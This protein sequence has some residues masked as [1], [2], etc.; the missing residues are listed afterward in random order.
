VLFVCLTISHL[1]LKRHFLL[2]GFF[3]L[4]IL[5]SKAQAPAIPIPLAGS[6]VAAA[7]D[8]VAALYD[9]YKHKRQALP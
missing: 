5:L 8:T 7:L 3:L 6:E 1:F 9:F 4:A 2:L